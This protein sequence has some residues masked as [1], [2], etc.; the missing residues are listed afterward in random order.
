MNKK[1]NGLALKL[2]AFTLLMFGFGF[3]LVPL[4]DV[5]CEVTGLNGKTGSIAESQAQTGEVDEK[6]LVTVE[7]IAHLNQSMNWSFEPVTEKL[8]VNPGKIY[9][10]DYLATNHNASPTIGRAVPSVAPAAAA[11]FFN[12]IECFC[13][14]EQRLAPDEQKTMPVRF[15][16]NADLPQHINTVSL[17]YTFFDISDHSNPDTI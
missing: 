10:V 12:K 5:I 17:A 11:A 4:Y 9:E 13:F 1:N 6:R 8:E 3:G 14:S 16:I 15:V 7:F 2:T